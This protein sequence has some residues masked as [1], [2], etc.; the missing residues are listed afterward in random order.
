[1]DRKSGCGG[2]RELGRSPSTRSAI[3]ASQVC[4]GL[5]VAPRSRVSRSLVASQ[6]ASFQTMTT[7]VAHLFH[8]LQAPSVGHSLGCPRVHAQSREPLGEHSGAVLGVLLLYR[9]PWCTAVGSPFW[10]DEE[11]GCGRGAGLGLAG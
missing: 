9:Q 6:A 2:A 7:R 4:G 3:S 11:G 1:V 5:C 8:A 10:K